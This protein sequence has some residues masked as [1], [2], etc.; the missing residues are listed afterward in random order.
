MPKRKYPV[1]R[2]CK[3]CGQKFLMMANATYQVCP[4]CEALR[5][6]TPIEASTGRTESPRH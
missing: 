4:K 2:L 6:E 3:A 1:F 5:D